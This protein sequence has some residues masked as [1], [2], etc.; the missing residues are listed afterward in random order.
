MQE[1]ATKYVHDF[2]VR[3]GE[4]SCTLDLDEALQTIMKS[5]EEC[6]EADASAIHLLDPS[7]QTVTIT[8]SRNLSERYLGQQKI[9]VADDPV[10]TKVLSGKVT[11]VSDI[12]GDPEHE[13]LVNL[14]GV[15]SFICAPLKSRARII[16]ALWAFF[17]KKREATDEEISYVATLA[18]QGGVALGNARMHLSLHIISDIGK[19]L[20]SRFD[21][22]EILQRIVTSAT[23]LFGGKGASIFM[24]NPL[25]NTLEMQASH[26]LSENFYEKKDL[27]I[28]E[29]V[30]KCLDELIAISDV[31]QEKEPQFPERL[32]QEGL[33]SV[34]CSPLRV[35]GRAIG[36]LRVY[37]DHVREYTA[38]D[39]MF[40]QVLA[41]FGGIAVENARLYG[42]IKRDYEDLTRDVWHWYDWGERSPRI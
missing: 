4:V 15:H 9:R 38:E 33:R 42:H 21:I 22:D 13:D 14:E 35:R 34:L 20:T 11:A 31:T 32:E 19:A 25:K 2:C 5:V 36:I 26:G 39:R 12:S 10:L 29:A 18:S 37:M 24:V 6:L 16:G 27:E 1:I 30:K 40:F 17:R 7:G 8:A 41:D 23:E 3:C 28:N